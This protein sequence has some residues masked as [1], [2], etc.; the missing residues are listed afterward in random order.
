MVI[1][2]PLTQIYHGDFRNYLERVPANVLVV[3]D[4]PYNIGF[5][6]DEYTDDLPDDD[7]VEMLCELQRFRRLAIVHY[8][9]EMMQWVLPALGVPDHV[10]AWCVNSNLPNRLRLIAYYGVTP[11]YTRIRQPYKNLT[12]KRIRERVNN[13][14]IGGQL[15]EWWSDINLVKNVTK[16]DKSHPCP[17][18]EALARRIIALCANPGD[19]IFDPFAGSGTTLAA[20]QSLGYQS[21]GCEL[22]EKYIEMA[23]KRL[24]QMPMTMAI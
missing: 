21:I 12:D 20:A 11:D 4:P 14:E 18:P 6:Y 3:T 22:S 19:V 17:I 8:P 15:Y 9:V 5:K 10:G 1:A 16:G 7:Y 23:G 2:F 13:G 24:N